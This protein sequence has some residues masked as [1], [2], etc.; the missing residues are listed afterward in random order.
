MRSLLSSHRTTEARTAT[1]SGPKL[2][3]HHIT[4]AK[5]LLPVSCVQQL[6]PECNLRDTLI[7][8]SG[9]RPPPTANNAPPAPF[10]LPGMAAST[11][12]EGALRLR[13]T[14]A[15]LMRTH[16]H[17]PVTRRWPKPGCSSL[18]S[19]DA[20]HT[21]ILFLSDRILR[22]SYWPPRPNCTRS[23]IFLHSTQQFAHPAEL[24]AMERD[25]RKNTLLHT[26][27]TLICAVLYTAYSCD[28]CR[29]L[30]I[31]ADCVLHRSI[32]CS[33]PPPMTLR[34]RSLGVFWSCS[35]AWVYS[36]SSA[37]LK[38]SPALDGSD[39][40]E[41][42]DIGIDLVVLKQLIVLRSDS[43]AVKLHCHTSPRPRPRLG[44]TQPTIS[45]AGTYTCATLWQQPLYNYCS[46][47]K[48]H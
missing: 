21:A 5:W 41:R 29:A 34:A 20:P 24:N 18:H 7:V 11:A 42:A 30:P 45:Y 10:S 19:L 26:S 40:C 36:N 2:V 32:E 15:P 38:T 23:P 9:D 25:G 39:S 44:S 27:P 8:H 17:H 33:V 3:A 14:C 16:H 1:L 43:A 13:V 37:A 12:S 47:V 6:Q 22:L 31:V 28:A 35:L 4:D 46:N 48:S